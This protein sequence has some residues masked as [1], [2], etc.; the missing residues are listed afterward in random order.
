MAAK[1]LPSP[2]AFHSPGLTD[3]K[4]SMSLEATPNIQLEKMSRF[5]SSGSFPDVTHPNTALTPKALP[6]HLR[7]RAFSLCSLHEGL[8]KEFVPQGLGRVVRQRVLSWTPRCTVPQKVPDG[9]PSQWGLE[10]GQEGA[11]RASQARP[12]QGRGA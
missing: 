1:R 12:G 2:R 11:T 6:C 8:E 7:P 3:V 9:F 5:N 10:V 4:R